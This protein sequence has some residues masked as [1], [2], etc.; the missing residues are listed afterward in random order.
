MS[1]QHTPGPWAVSS[2]TACIFGAKRGLGLEPIGLIYHPALP[3]NSAVGLR[4]RADAA[5]CAAAPELLDALRE[6]LEAHRSKYPAFEFG[7]DAQN[8]W[9][10]RTTAA[11]NTA[12]LVIAKATASTTDAG[13]AG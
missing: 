13:V 5:L 4:A 3:D 9:V 6:L 12:E 2:N 1:G 7:V 11:R 8:A 10:E